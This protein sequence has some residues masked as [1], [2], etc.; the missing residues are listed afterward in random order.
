M[1]CIS[2]FA[3]AKVNLYL[4]ITSRLPN[5]YHAID[6]V[7][8]RVGLCDTVSLQKTDGD[9]LLTCSN[10][11][12]PC[13]EGNLAYRAAQTYRERFG[14]RQGVQIDLQKVIPQGAGLAGGS[15]DAA[16]VLLA[17]NELFCAADQSELHQAATALGADVPFCLTDGAARATGIGEVLEPCHPLPPCHLVILQGESPV[18]TA[19]AYSALDAVPRQIR[20]QNPMPDLLASGDLS[21]ICAGLYNAFE[22]VVPSCAH[23]KAQMTAF[24]AMGT[25]MSGS[26]SS[27]FGIFDTEDK[28]R[29]AVERFAQINRIAWYCRA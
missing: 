2:V 29:D 17:M 8:H 16:A 26:G 11:S 28:A 10:A 14:I 21:K 3:H 19:Q 6:T 13:D 9:V 12:L 4:E 18:S 25:L 23:D 7:M 24:G 20:T 5:G 15:A 1:D 22:A 27:V